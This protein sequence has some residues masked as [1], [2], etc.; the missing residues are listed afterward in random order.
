MVHS[1]SLS[2]G[3]QANATGHD[4][5]RAAWPQTM[6][7]PANRILPMLLDERTAAGRERYLTAFAN[8]ANFA[9][10]NRFF[11][12]MMLRAGL[13][14]IAADLTSRLIYDAPHNLLWP[15]ADG[16]V[17]HRKGATPAGGV[18]DHEHRGSELF[19]EPVIVPGSMGAPSYL[20]VGSATPA[21]WAAPAT[22]RAAASRGV[23][24][25]AAATRSWTPSCVSSGSSPRSITAIRRWPA[26]VR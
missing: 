26:A 15:G 14:D 19:G 6:P 21:R 7:M 2:L 4:Q 25:P 1:G 3:H 17:V 10:G 18:T 22:A 11:L 8:A 16:T 9:I 13:A 24:R 20:C 23:R 5:A 12:A